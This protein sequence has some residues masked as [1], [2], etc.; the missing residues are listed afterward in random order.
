MIYIVV[1]L[2]FLLFSAVSLP[3]LLRGG[4]LPI[5]ALIGPL[6]IVTQRFDSCVPDHS[7]FEE[8]DYLARSFNRMTR[9]IHDQR[10]ESLFQSQSSH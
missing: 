4:W 5:M 6:M 2:I 9:Q 8:F 7:G 10:N 3:W 1:A